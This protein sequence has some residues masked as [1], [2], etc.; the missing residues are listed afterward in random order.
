MEKLVI[1]FAVLAGLFAVL[2]L[3]ALDYARKNRDMYDKLLDEK[4]NLS[5]E[6][7]LLKNERLRL[8]AQRDEYRDL[9]FEKFEDDRYVAQFKKTAAAADELASNLW[10]RYTK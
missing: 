5:S 1:V 7:L 9:Y 8:I 6:N 4:I 3:I 10:K 2:W